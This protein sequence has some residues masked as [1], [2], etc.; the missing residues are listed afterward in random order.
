[1]LVVNAV[2]LLVFSSCI[3]QQYRF[4]V[5]YFMAIQ[6]YT[7]QLLCYGVYKDSLKKLTKGN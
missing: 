5:L 6:H 1:M 2:L 7:I 4:S 3:K